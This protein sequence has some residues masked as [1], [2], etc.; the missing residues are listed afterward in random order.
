MDIA[1]WSGNPDPQKE[2]KL[3]TGWGFIPTVEY[4][5]FK[6]LNLK[7]FTNYA[8]RVF[9]YTEYAKNR[10]G[11]KNSTTG[12]VSLGFVAPLHVL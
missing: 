9:N 8:G 7:F 4:F 12:V 1:S 6:D 3:R 10:L 11:Q 2:K 5:P